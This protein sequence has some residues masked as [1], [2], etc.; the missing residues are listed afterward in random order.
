ML[1][2]RVLPDFLSGG[3][4]ELF[5]QVGVDRVEITAGPPAVEVPFHQIRRERR[6]RIDH[7]RPDLERARAD[8]F[9]PDRG[10]DLGDGFAVTASP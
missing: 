7:G 9:Q 2:W 6:G 3:P 4:A 1:P 10:P 8:A 5:A